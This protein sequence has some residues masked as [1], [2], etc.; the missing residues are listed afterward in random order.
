[1]RGNTTSGCSWRP[2]AGRVPQLTPARRPSFSSQ[3]PGRRELKRANP[4]ASRD[5]LS[6]SSHLMFPSRGDPTPLTDHQ[7]YGARP[8]TPNS[9]PHY[10]GGARTQQQELWQLPHSA[11]SRWGP[12]SALWSPPQY[13]CPANLCGHPHQGRRRRRGTA[14]LPAGSGRGHT[15]LQTESCFRERPFCLFLSLS[16][17]ISF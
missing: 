14:N 6:L 9:Q 10:A 7:T 17:L 8:S 12:A 1:M 5:Q 11:G 3:G 2:G 4:A 16:F 13:Q 15:S